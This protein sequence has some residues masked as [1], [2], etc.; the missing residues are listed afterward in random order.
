LLRYSYI[1]WLLSICQRINCQHCCTVQIRIHIL[2]QI[3][4]W[5]LNYEVH[6]NPSLH[7][8]CTAARVLRVKCSDNY[9]MWAKETK[10]LIFP[11]VDNDISRLMAC[12]PYKWIIFSLNAWWY[13]AHRGTTAEASTT[14]LKIPATILKRN[15]VTRRLWDQ[16][17]CY[18]ASHESYRNNWME[19]AVNSNSKCRRRR[20]SWSKW[21]KERRWPWTSRFYYSGGLMFKSW[22]PD[23]QFWLN[24]FRTFPQVLKTNYGDFPQIM[25]RATPSTTSQSIIQ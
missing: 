15:Y 1:A 3:S 4:K 10:Q 22:H 2:W 13:H 20:H 17:P 6:K 23:R 16:Y 14:P 11:P 21:L 7:A 19:L 18:S 5:I 24:V 8:W 12:R 9:G 25:L